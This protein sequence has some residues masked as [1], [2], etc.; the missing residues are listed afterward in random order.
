[1]DLLFKEQ[2]ITLFLYTCL[3]S[4]DPLTSLYYEFEIQGHEIE[5]SFSFSGKSLVEETLS[6]DKKVILERIKN[7]AKLQLES[8]AVFHDVEDSLLF[9]RRVYF[10]TRFAGNDI[11]IK[12]F[13]FLKK[14][15]YIDAYTR[16]VRTYNGEKLNVKKYLEEH[17][18]EKINRFFRDYKFNYEI[19]YTQAIGNKGVYY[20]LSDDEGKEIFFQR[21]GIDVPIPVFMESAGN[22]TLVNMLPSILEVVERGGMLIIDEFSSSLH[23]KLEELLV[24]Y[25]MKVGKETQLF[26]VSHSTNLLSNAILR[27]DQ[28][29][30]VEME[31]EEGSKLNRFS[32]EQPRLAQNI[33]KMYL[34]GVFGGIPEYGTN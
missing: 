13:E 4:N 17:G 34:G 12:W 25:I 10:N 7:N 11:L 15:I 16:R 8:E 9:L 18:T 30:S 22:Q 23:N 28:I 31:G 26:F 32:N 3:F 20:E 1:M 29:Y 24:K 14:S 19:Q 33:E 5:Y 27:P 21:K 2:D 6:V